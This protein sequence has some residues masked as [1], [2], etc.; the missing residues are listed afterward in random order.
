VV[1]TAFTNKAFA[2]PLPGDPARLAW[3]GVGAALVVVGVTVLSHSP[4]L[5]GDPRAE[6]DQAGPPVRSAAR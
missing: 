1:A 4:L 3:L 2:E 5:T 6:A